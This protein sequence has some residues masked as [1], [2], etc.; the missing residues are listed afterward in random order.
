MYSIPGRKHEY[1]LVESKGELWR[2]THTAYMRFLSGGKRCGQ[3]NPRDY[4]ELIGS[5]DAAVTAWDGD[6]YARELR[7]YRG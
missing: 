7:G 1:Y 5:V 2:M 6:D 4:G 3:A